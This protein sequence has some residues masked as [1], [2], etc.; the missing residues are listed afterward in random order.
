MLVALG[1]VFGGGELEALPHH[2][3]AV[4]H[5]RENRDFRAHLCAD[6]VYLYSAPQRF[7]CICIAPLAGA[8]LIVCRLHTNECC[9]FK[10]GSSKTAG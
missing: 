1:D 9:V 8:L 3:M 6:A 5:C 7:V 10:T 2:M 4:C